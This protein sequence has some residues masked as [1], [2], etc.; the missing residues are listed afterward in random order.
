[1]L[2][3]RG[4]FDLY[5]VKKIHHGKQNQVDLRETPKYKRDHG[6]TMECVGSQS[7]LQVKVRENLQTSFPK[8][9]F[10]A[11]HHHYHIQFKMGDLL[12]TMI[13]KDRSSHDAYHKLIVSKIGPLEI[14]EKI[15]ANAYGLVLRCPTFFKSNI[16]STLSQMNINVSHEP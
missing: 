2:H 7:L 14:L 4:K 12:S 9:T 15:N 13:T 5:K 1:M 3:L 8:Y 16:C 10:T 11:Q 6:K